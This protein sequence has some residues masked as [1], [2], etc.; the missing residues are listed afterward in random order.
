[1][2]GERSYHRIVTVVAHGAGPDVMGVGLYTIAEA[3]RLVRQRSNTVRSWVQKGL[4]PSPIRV[5][6]GET[7][8]LSFFDL[9]SLLVVRVLRQKSIELA[10]IREAE[11]YLRKDWGL[12][13]PFAEARIYTGGRSVRTA[14][15]RGA[16]LTSIDRRGQEVIQE[17]IREDLVDVTYGANKLAASWRPWDSVLLRPDIQFGAPCVEGTR[18]TTSSIFGLHAAGDDV[19]TIAEWY[20]LPELTVSAA[21]AFEESLR[22]PN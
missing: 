11:S 7:T 17:V 15:E 8:V 13:R 18:V 21:V 14:L 3:G 19:T 6:F 12:E 4:A 16:K 9:V 1:M 5:R 2:R 20:E 10:Q 22:R